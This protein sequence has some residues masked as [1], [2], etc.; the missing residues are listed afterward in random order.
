MRES[1]EYYR[2]RFDYTYRWHT[3]MP[4]SLSTI[5]DRQIAQARIVPR[6]ELPALYT[7][8]G[9]RV[10]KR[11]IASSSNASIDAAGDVSGWSAADAARLLLLLARA[12]EAP[13]DFADAALACFEHGDAGEQIS[14]LRAVSVYPSPGQF[15]AHVIDSCRTNIVPLFEAIACEN[16]YPAEHFPE[17]NFNQ[18]VLKSLFNNI[19]LARIVG[20]ERR[21]NADLSRMADDYVSEREAAGRAVPTDI[22]VALAPYASDAAAARVARYAADAD[23]AHRRWAAAG[24]EHRRALHTPRRQS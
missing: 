24:L 23:P 13:E 16:P 4:A 17:R 11:P 6:A 5:S 19:A 20:L 22:W 18:L 7:I 9:R 15:L 1:R 12:D 10:G 3:R 8:V 14:W 2:G 21:L